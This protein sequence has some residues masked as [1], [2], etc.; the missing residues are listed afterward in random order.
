MKLADIEHRLRELRREA[1]V[2]R[3]RIARLEERV[4]ELVRVVEQK[5]E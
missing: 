5:S 1:A 2:N 4:A 3:E